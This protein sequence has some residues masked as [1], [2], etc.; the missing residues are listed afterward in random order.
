MDFQIVINILWHIAAA[1]SFVS[2][3]AIPLF[4]YIYS[5][6][7]PDDEDVHLFQMMKL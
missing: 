7:I 4:L 2:L 3:S 6:F 1:F 5:R